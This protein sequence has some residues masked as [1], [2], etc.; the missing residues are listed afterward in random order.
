MEYRCRISTPAGEVREEVVAAESESRLRRDLEERGLVL[1]AARPAGALAQ[2]GLS[3]A[4]WPPPARRRGAAREFLVFNQELATLLK[5]GMPLVQS[6][7]ILRQR[8]Q[9]PAFKAALDDVH[10]RVRAGAA[11]SEA[12]AQ[13]GDLFP[14][15][16]TASLMAGEKSGGLEQVLRRY[17]AYVKV[18]SAV[19]RKTMSALIYPAI[20]S[21]LSVVVVAVIVVRVVPAF[22][23]FYASFDRELPLLTRLIV[24]ASA[25]LV[26]WWPLLLAAT[27]GAGLG[28]WWWLRQPSRRVALHRWLLRLPL[29]GPTARKFATSQLARTLATLLGG[30]IPLVNAITVAIVRRLVKVPH[31]SLVNLLA[32]REVVPERLQEFCTPESL[33]EALLRPMLDPGVAAAQRA[34]FAEALGKLRAPEGL[35]S[36]A[37]AQAVLAALP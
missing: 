26:R 34:G 25:A 30:G 16:Y 36:V 2:T 32:E 28:G 33:A 11:L 6:L 27:L 35:P 12:F 18:V 21:G 24:G 4:A 14:G 5:A 17:V 20:L 22:A 37:A 1:L 3:A 31:A 10:D 9:N 29:V 8:V 13:Q 23:D 19:R 7:D 15:I